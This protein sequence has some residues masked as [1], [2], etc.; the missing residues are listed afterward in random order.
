MSQADSSATFD[1]IARAV[2][3]DL[4]IFGFDFVARD[5]RTVELQSPDAC[6]SFGL[7]AARDPA[8]TFVEGRMRQRD[9][10]EPDASYSLLE[11]I[12]HLDPARSD[13]EIRSEFGLGRFPANDVAE[14]EA[15]LTRLAER[16]CQVLRR[17]GPALSSEELW[18]ELHIEGLNRALATAGDT[19]T[20]RA[21]SAFRRGDYAETVA[22][23]ERAPGELRPA[24]RKRL[25]IARSRLGQ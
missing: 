24:E 18:T 16:W 11:L 2:L 19:R 10:D 23:Y 4:T 8:F 20:E 25:E 12:R 9:S 3:A 22:L 13:L 15:S 14:I 17:L 1:G 7:V 6:L 5:E 21:A